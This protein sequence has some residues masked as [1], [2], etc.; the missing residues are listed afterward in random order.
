MSYDRSIMQSYSE[1]FHLFLPVLSL[2]PADNTLS[3]RIKCFLN[4]IFIGVH[5]VVNSE[6]KEKVQAM[7]YSLSNGDKRIIVAK[8]D[9][10]YVLKVMIYCHQE[11][12]LT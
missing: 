10:G 11:P 12:M 5:A 9:F 2:S 1:K 6:N 7:I 8:D 4:C 3:P